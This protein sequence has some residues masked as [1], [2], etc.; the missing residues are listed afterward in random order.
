M[1]RR[2]QLSELNERQPLIGII[3]VV[4][5]IISALILIVSKFYLD[6]K[7]QTI[8]PSP[9]M[10]LQ[11][12]NFPT[13]QL[14]HY[15]IWGRKDDNS[16]V[17]IKRFNSIDNQLKNLDGSD[18]TELYLEGLDDIQS[19]FVTI[20][21]E[22]DR[23]E[24]PNDFVL[25]DSEIVQNRAE[26]IFDLDIPESENYFIL[27]TPTDGNSTINEMSGLWFKDEVD[28]LPG[29]KL[30]NSPQKFKYE[31][32]I[33]NPVVE[34]ALYLGRFDNVKEEDNSKIYSLS[35]EGFKFPGED[36]LRNLPEPLE[37]P[38]NLANGNYQIIVSLEPDSDGI[39]NTG[40]DVF[41]RLLSLEIPRNSAELQNIP[42]NT[43][44]KP[45][46]LTIELNE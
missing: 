18:L 39:D 30:P 14:G 42:M 4:T 20:E 23:D 32:R 22:G 33:I 25:M 7:N 41:L 21:S 29:L 46:Q 2:S 36:L 5:I 8:A 34:R 19:I 26:L 38:L 28:E 27:A 6:G 24:T 17:F 44:Y 13:I 15:A 31:A 43:D 40:E 35:S 1:R 10:T 3:I 37:A 12:D 11:S 9:S 45:I 16:V